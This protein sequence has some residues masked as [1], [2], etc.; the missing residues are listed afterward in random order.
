MI[1]ITLGTQDKPFT[2]LLN[3]VQKEIDAGNIKDNVIV[4]AG[5]TKYKSKNMKLFDFLPREEF[6]KKMEKCDLLITHGGVGSIIGGLKLGK[7]IIAVPRLAKY[8]EHVN[9]HQK[10]IIDIFDK[11][12]YIIGI[13]DLKDLPKAL[14]KAKK[15]KPKKY[16]SNTQ[17]FIK[18]L[19]KIIDNIYS[20]Y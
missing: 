14:K 7:K 4:Q 5:C 19:A 8:K 20:H 17:N 16:I 18:T 11:K 10:Q 3:A 6:S 12:G 1:F 15:F 2:R 9:D 13:T